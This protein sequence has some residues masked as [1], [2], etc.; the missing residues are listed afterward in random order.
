MLQSSCASGQRCLNCGKVFP[1]FPPIYGGCPACVSEGFRAPLEL[2]FEYP[3]QND[4]IPQQPLPGLERYAPALPPLAAGVSMGEGGTPLVRYHDADFPLELWVK[5][6]SRNPTWSHKDRLNVCTV[7]AAV[8]RG[9]RGIVAASSGN[10]GASAAAYAARAGLPAIILTTKRPGSLAAYLGAYQQLVVAVPTPE[11]RWVLMERVVKEFGF[12]PASNQTDPPTNHPFGSE[13]YKTIAYELFL[14]LGPKL[15]EA[16]FVPV[17]YAELIF[18]IYKGFNELRQFGLIHELPRLI[19]CEPG[20]AGPLTEAYQDGHKIARVTPQNTG[21]YSIAVPANSYRGI[22]ALKE[23][24]GLAVR[25]S[26]TEIQQ[27]QKKLAKNG[28]WGELSSAVAF[29]AA[30]K[31]EQFGLGKGPLVSINTSSGF[32]DYDIDQAKTV[33]IDGSWEALLQAVRAFGF[34][35]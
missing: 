22:V 14:Q 23:T 1:L 6:E 3:P 24:N 34:N 2:T 5:D 9:A 27:A 26:E 17:G 25:V 11:T 28:L 16:I 32:K 8:K 19:A 35:L 20:A 30:L 21:A 29:A 18:G 15:P 12:E 10:H 7:S 31:A 13:G 4:W 33:E